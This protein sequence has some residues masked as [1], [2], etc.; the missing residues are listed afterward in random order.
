[1][2]NRSACEIAVYDMDQSVQSGMGIIY[3]YAALKEK[4]LC[5]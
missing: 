4:R 3:R 2:V 5:R 1:M